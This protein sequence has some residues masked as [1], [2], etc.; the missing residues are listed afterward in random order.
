MTDAVLVTGATGFI[1][2]HLVTAIRALGREVV[3]L[4][5][6]DG[7]IARVT[8]D[9]EGVGHV[10]HLA[11][12]SYVPGSWSAP[13]EYYETNVLGTVNVLE[14]CR[15]RR[16]PM[17]YVSSYVYGIPQ[18]LPIDE[19][20]P[21]QP[22]NPYSHSKIVAEDIVAYYAAQF[23]VRSVVV[24]PFNVYGP[25]QDERF[26]VPTVVRQALDPGNDRI[27]VTD[28][29]PKRDFLF[30]AD[31]VSL[32]IT[33]LST[34]AGGAYNAGSGTSVSIAALVDEVNAVLPFPK[35]LQSAHQV[36]QA[37][38]FDVVADISRARRELKWQPQV[39]LRDGVRRTMEWAGS[40]LG[41]QR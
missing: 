35:R 25:G 28:E 22:T 3:A 9:R 30:I 6:R 14:F 29:R 31:L 32:L 37:E 13:R 24:R 17:T 7:D 8:I 16:T 20:H 1:G 19:T 11:G 36:R 27:V 40:R 5:S 41:V 34:D 15:R 38:L 39:P 2:T 23:G 12:K 21:L 4:S 18:R 33:T 10:V 26:V